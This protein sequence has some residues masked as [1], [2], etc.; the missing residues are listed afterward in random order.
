MNISNLPTTTNILENMSTNIIMDDRVIN[1]LEDIS[2]EISALFWLILILA[3]LGAFKTKI[4][5]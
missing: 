2:H 5:R 1:A 4:E 3:I